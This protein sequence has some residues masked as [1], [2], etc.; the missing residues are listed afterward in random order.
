MSINNFNP[1]GGTCASSIEKSTQKGPET[2]QKKKGMGDWK[3]KGTCVVP[4]SL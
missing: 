1:E 4:L 2:S 3:G